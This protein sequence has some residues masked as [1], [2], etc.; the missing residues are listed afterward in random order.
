[1][2][3]DDEEM[4]QHD[5]AHD[6]AG[7]LQEL[8]EEFLEQHPDA[9][10]TAFY[11]GLCIMEHAW[12]RHLLANGASQAHL[13][14][15]KLSTMPCSDKL[16]DYLRRNGEVFFEYIRSQPPAEPD[17]SDDSVEDDSMEF[18]MSNMPKCNVPG[19]DA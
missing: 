6:L 5:Y 19:G 15:T 16:S 9:D 18:A 4:K 2:S 14:G 11:G 12:Q 7:Q 10:P 13:L 1:V 8:F 17:D 3:N